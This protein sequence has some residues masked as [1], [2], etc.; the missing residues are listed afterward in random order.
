MQ[1]A[2]EL[3]D[4]LG[5]QV[6][7]HGNV[8]QFV[9]RAIE[10]MLSEEKRSFE[11]HNDLMDGLP[12]IACFENKDPLS[13]QQGVRDESLNKNKRHFLN[14][15][16][17]IKPVKAPFSSEEM[18]AMLREGKEQQLIDAQTSHGK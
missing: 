18:V 8:Q 7:Q 11:L 13:I 16:R 4:E 17:N 14:H 2:I 5:Q 3:P 9:Q 6:L 10:R 1:L 15:I 12:E